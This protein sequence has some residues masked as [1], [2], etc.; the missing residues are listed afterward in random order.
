MLRST[1][2]VIMYIVVAILL[3]YISG[4]LSAAG[5]SPNEEVVCTVPARSRSVFC[6]AF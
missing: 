5:C 3:L 2:E 4:A 1:Y 6:R